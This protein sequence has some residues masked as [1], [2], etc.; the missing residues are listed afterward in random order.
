MGGRIS[1][2]QREGRVS[3]CLGRGEK[4][5]GV[6]GVERRWFGRVDVGGRGG[7]V[8]VGGSGL[9]TWIWFLDRFGFGIQFCYFLVDF[10]IYL[11]FFYVFKGNYIL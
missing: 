11:I 8:D 3:R 2:G 6:G 5:I 9:D 7:E 10:E 4:V 1:R